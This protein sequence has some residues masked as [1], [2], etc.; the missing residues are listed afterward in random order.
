MEPTQFLLAS[1]CLL[2][3]SESGLSFFGWL[4]SL[5][6]GVVKLAIIL[7]CGALGLG[8]WAFS[9]AWRKIRQSEHRTRLTAM[10]LDRG[11]SAEQIEKVIQAGFIGHDP[12]ADESPSSAAAS[13][14]PEVRLVKHLSDSQYE[15]ADVQKIVA[16]ARRDGKIDEATVQ[17]VETL[18]SN[19]EDTDAIVALLESRRERLA[20]DAAK[21][22]VAPTAA[23]LAV[24]S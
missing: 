14:D 24:N 4:S 9:S 21:P 15:G 11:M 10:M 13:A 23:T 5:D 2:G 3:D 22:G 8:A 17:I 19:W 7:F 12:D 6:E 1:E 18:A 16:A 20:A